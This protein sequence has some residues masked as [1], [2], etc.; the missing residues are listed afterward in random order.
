MN[1]SQNVYNVT[2]SSAQLFREI[3]GEILFT[4][5]K[6]TLLTTKILKFLGNHKYVASTCDSH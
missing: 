4:T 5:A 1:V 2:S 3:H 6:Q